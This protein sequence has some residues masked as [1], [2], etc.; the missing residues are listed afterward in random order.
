[1]RSE[2]RGACELPGLDPLT[3]ANEGKLL[4]IVAL[5][6]AD[7]TLAAMRVHPLGREAAIIGT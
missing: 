4:A 6:D 7:A 2:V 5:E 1:M 3:I